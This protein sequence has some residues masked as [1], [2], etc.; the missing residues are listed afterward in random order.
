MDL[1]EPSTFS[2]IYSEHAGEVE[3]IARRVVG[4]TAQAQDVTHDVFLRLWLNPGTF[5][6][7][8]GDVGKYLR[9]LARSR[10][11]DATRTRGAAGRASERLRESAP[12]PVAGPAEPRGDERERLVRALRR[13]P[14]PQ[15]EALVLS[16]WADL[17]DHEVAH[18]AG[19]PLGTAKSR[20]RLGLRRLR[21]DAE[22]LTA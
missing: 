2:R 6:P 12:E 22:L 4:C 20:I 9:M 1:R 3:A 10:A 18:H 21:D 14:G 16:Y 19:V 7:A 15:R 8:R 11:I 5:D 17:R 13:L